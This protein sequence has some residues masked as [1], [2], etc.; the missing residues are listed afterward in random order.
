MSSIPYEFPKPV[1]KPAQYTACRMLRLTPKE[2]EALTKI[3]AHVGVPVSVLVRSFIEHGIK[4]SVEKLKG[5]N[6]K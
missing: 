5:Q 6:G 2:H 4:M 3:A 1:R